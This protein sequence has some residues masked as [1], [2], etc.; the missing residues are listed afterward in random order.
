MDN[1]LKTNSLD[2]A[3]EYWQQAQD[4]LAADMPSVPMLSSKPPAAAQLYV[5]GFVPNSTLTELF[6]TVWLADH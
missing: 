1:A 3:K 4:F 5:K 2:K 6:N